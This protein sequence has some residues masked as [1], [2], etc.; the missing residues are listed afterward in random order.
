LA[1]K[2]LRILGHQIIFTPLSYF[3][4]RVVTPESVLATLCR[5]SLFELLDLPLATALL[6]HIDT[7]STET[8]E[9]HH[10]PLTNLAR[11]HSTLLG[12][13]GSAAAELPSLDNASLNGPALHNGSILCLLLALG[14]LDC[15]SW[16]LGQEN[17]VPDYSA[18]GT[19]FLL[20]IC[21]SGTAADAEGT[22]SI[23]AA[24]A[25]T[26]SATDI[27]EGDST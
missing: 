27:P 19:D 15:S 3:L 12:H 16:L 25:Y 13:W 18:S 7:S 5:S 14:L 9:R 22:A 8:H 6:A 20:A 2:E 11:A 10:A 24:E 26:A 23:T 21:S 17:E 1:N 4:L